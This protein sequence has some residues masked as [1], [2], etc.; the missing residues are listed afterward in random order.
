MCRAPVT[1]E[2]MPMP[3]AMP[4]G[5]LPM[6]QG[7]IHRLTTKPGGWALK[8]DTQDKLKIDTQDMPKIDTVH[9]GAPMPLSSKKGVDTQNRLTHQKQI[10]AKQKRIQNKSTT[11]PKDS[12][13][14]L[15]GV[16]AQV[17]LIPQTVLAL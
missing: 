12:L 17:S 7:T 13:K 4:N 8:I 2:P 6:R 9:A 16:H 10:K 5:F 3:M 14:T 15:F 1:N 11:K